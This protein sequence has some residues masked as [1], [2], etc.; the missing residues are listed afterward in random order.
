[1]R[2]RER[3]QF[4]HSIWWVKAFGNFNCCAMLLLMNLLRVTL[5]GIVL[6]IASE[7]IL[8]CSQHNENLLAQQRAVLSELEFKILKHQ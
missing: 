6:T 5:A 8:H 3:I 4:H 2:Q 1:M 7:G